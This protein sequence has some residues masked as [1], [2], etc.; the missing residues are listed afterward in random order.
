MAEARLREGIA[1][2]LNG[3]E[4]FKAKLAPDY[5]PYADYDQL[6]RLEEWVGRD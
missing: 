4:P 6:M 1:R 2:W 5:A 3:D